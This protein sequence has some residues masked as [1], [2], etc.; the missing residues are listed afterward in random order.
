MGDRIGKEAL[1]APYVAKL[2]EENVEVNAI[3]DASFKLLR[4]RRELKKDRAELTEAGAME[5]LKVL[6]DRLT[7]DNKAARIAAER[8]IRK[9]YQYA[10]QFMHPPDVSHGNVQAAARLIL[11]RVYR[12]SALIH[13]LEVEMTILDL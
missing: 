7:C 8:L 12:T 11:R 6:G 2:Q 5:F 10:R 13:R 3:V 9:E 1:E 4:V